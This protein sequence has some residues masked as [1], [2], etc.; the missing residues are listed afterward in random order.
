MQ[1]W[2]ATTTHGVT[3]KEAQKRLQDTE[4]LKQKELTGKR[5]LLI[6]DFKILVISVK[7]R[8]VSVISVKY[9][10]TQISTLI[11]FLTDI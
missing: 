11:I 7:Y 3:R 9:R 1:D 8:F 5:S 10:F 4:N 6:V 2:T